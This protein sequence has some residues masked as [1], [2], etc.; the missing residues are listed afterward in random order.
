MAGAPALET[1]SGEFVAG[2]AVKHLNEIPTG[3]SMVE[4]PENTPPPPAL[5]P[6]NQ[7]GDPTLVHSDG[8]ATPTPADKNGG[9][10]SGEEENEEIPLGYSPALAKHTSAES[11]AVKPPSKTIKKFDKYYHQNLGFIWVNGKRFN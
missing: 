5:L 9:G 3:K 4:V 7:L 1:K 8:C 6:D 2:N 11:A 10:K